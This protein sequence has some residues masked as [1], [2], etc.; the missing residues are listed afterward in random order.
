MKR[1]HLK[2]NATKTNLNDKLTMILGIDIERIVDPN[3]QSGHLMFGVGVEYKVVGLPVQ[4]MAS[5]V[6]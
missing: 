5:S 1:F 6:N 4:N 3:Q 2:V